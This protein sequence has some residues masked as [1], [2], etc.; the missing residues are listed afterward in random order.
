MLNFRKGT[1]QDELLQYAE[2]IHGQDAVAPVTPAAVCKA[3]KNLRYPVFIDL[4]QVVVKKFSTHFTLQ[5]WHGFRLLAVDGST[6]RL[7]N[8]KDI[9]QT[10][11]G[12]SDASCLMARFSR[13]YDV[14]NK[15]I[16]RAHIEP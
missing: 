2:A 15:V 6:C 1:L 8:T 12:P 16:V 13:L 14:M 3:R 7:P 10:F 4:N 9:T 11:G 5:R